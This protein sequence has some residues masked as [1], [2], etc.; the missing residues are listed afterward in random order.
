[1]ETIK[2]VRKTGFT[3]APEAGTQRLRNVINKRITDDDIHRT[4]EDAFRLGWRVIKLYFMIGLP[5]ETDQD[6]QAAITLVKDLRNRH[7][8]RGQ[9]NASAAAFIPKPHTPFQWATQMGLSETREKIDRIRSQ[10]NVSGIHFKWQ[11][12]EMSILEG[13][14]ARGDRRLGKLLIEAFKRG[15]RL[16]GWSDRLRFD[17]WESSLSDSGVDIDFFTTRRRDVTEPLPWDHIDTRVSK[18]FLQTEWSKGL[19]G[20]AT[21]DCRLDACSRCGV[22]DFKVVQPKLLGIATE[23]EPFESLKA[24][25]PEKPSLRLKVSY[26]KKDQARYFGHLELKNIFHRAIRRAGIPVQYSEGFHPLPK[27]S[28]DDP[29]PVGMESEGESLYITVKGKILPETVKR[30]LN[31]KLCEG[32]TVFACELADKKKSHPSPL[33]TYRMVLEEGVFDAARIEEFR[34]RPEWLMDRS[35]RNGKIEQ[36]DLKETVKR[37]ELCSPSEIEIVLGAGGGVTLRPAEV[38]AKLFDL[39]QRTVKQARVIKQNG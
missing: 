34:K 17:L 33:A 23:E 13:L 4:V 21:P 29:L 32:L 11:N 37:L 36:I 9:V 8:R 15:C 38:A 5:T 6:L 10:L 31:D 19:S 28:F 20:E 30:S 24:Q 14:W 12:P 27:V 2:R 7:R 39:P 26:R 22:C 18:H 35:R 16:D 25:K 1:M 3:I